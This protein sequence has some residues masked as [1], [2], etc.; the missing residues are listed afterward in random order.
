LGTIRALSLSKINI[1]NIHANNDEAFI[2]AC[3]NGHIDVVKW[4]YSLEDK[5][6]IHD[7]NDEA[8]KLTCKNGHIY[9]AQW[10]STICDDY[11]FT[12]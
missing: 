1:P 3:E 6:D 7:K 9:V 2:N 11:Y 5:P 10:L 8:L 4:L 12:I